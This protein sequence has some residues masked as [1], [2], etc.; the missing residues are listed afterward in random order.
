MRA[1]AGCII[2][3]VLH[4][5]RSREGPAA[6]ISSVLMLGERDTAGSSGLK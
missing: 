4:A 1:A 5:V 3:E 2:S 6:I